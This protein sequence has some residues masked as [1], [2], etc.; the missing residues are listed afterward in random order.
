MKPDIQHYANAIKEANEAAKS[1]S[2]TDDGGTCNM[3]SVTIDFKGWR[4]T[5]IT[6]LQN[7]SGIRIGEKLSGHWRNS[8][9]IDTEAH[10]QG[11]NRTRMV[12]AAVNKL[13]EFNIPASVY[14][15]MD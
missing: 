13:K 2:Q 6:K 14:Y 10:G 5:D 15:Q 8:R 12:E 3:D 11:N 7:M 4:E 1:A 9:W